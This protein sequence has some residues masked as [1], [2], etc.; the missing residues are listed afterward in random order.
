MVLEGGEIGHYFAD[1]DRAQRNTVALIDVDYLIEGHFAM[2]E[3]AGPADNMYKFI[4][5]FARRVEKG[6]HYHQPYLGCREFPAEILSPDGAPAPIDETDD[7]GLMLW[8]LDYRQM[9]CRPLFFS[10][11]LDG[12]VLE[13][14]LDPEGSEISV[15]RGAAS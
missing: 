11:R 5:M 6:Q 4:D 8:D 7:L 2:T 9:P 1:E 10:A 13:V 14:P 12:G 15:P 3:R